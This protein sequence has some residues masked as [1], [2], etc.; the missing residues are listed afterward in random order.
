MAQ[1]G[2][3]TGVD[4][5]ESHHRRGGRTRRAGDAFSS[6]PLPLRRYRLFGIALLIAVPA[7]SRDGVAQPSRSASWPR[8][9]DFFTVDQMRSVKA[10]PTLA[11]VIGITP[12]ERLDGRVLTHALAEEAR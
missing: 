11:P 1:H 4:S 9:V 8:L 3:G 7:L 6:I 12:C 2:G 10:A 5:S